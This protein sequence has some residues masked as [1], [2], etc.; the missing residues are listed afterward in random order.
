MKLFR[1]VSVTACVVVAVL[2]ALS[3]DDR[4]TIVKFAA[5]REYINKGETAQLQW[6]IDGAVRATISPEL[7]PVDTS[8]SAIAH[9]KSTTSYELHGFAQDGTS[10]GRVLVVHV[11][12]KPWKPEEGKIEWS[13]VIGPDGRIVIEGNTARSGG[14]LTTGSLPGAPTTVIV[15]DPDCTVSEQP[16]AA[17]KF[18]SV[19]LACDKRGETT[20]R[21]HWEHAPPGPK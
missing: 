21:M 10:I 3:A 20:V 2:G 11:R 18:S 17:N 4:L 6:Q 1:A 7:G 12:E 13:G 15:D 9:P 19:V 5:V 14:I 8:G 16:N